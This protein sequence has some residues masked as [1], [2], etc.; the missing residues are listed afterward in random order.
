VLNDPAIDVI[1]E[2]I[3]GY[4]PARKFVLA[5]I[6]AGKDVVTANKALLAVYGEEIVA[7]AEARGVRLGFEASV[8]GGIPILRTLKEGLAGDRTS[9]VYGI[10]NGTCN[11]ILTTMSREGRGFDDVLAEAQRLGLAEANPATDVDGI[12]SAHKLA[13]LATLAFGVRPR[14]ADIPTEGIRRV[15]AIDIAFA[16]ELGYTIKLL[17]I[18]KDGRDA[19]EARVHPTMIPNGHLLADVSGAFNAIF[20]RGAA[21]G[22]TMYYGQGAGSLPTATA[23]IADLVAATRDRAVGADVRVPPWGVPQRALRALPVAPL[24]ALESEYYLRFMA[25]DR[26]GVLARIAGVLGR[27]DISIASVIQRDRRA[28]T[29]VPVVI[30]THRARERDL[31]KALAAIDALATVRG[32]PVAIRIEE[33]LG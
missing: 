30:R 31:A 29:A 10:V 11:H 28:G 4:E 13:L 25:T 2:L 20:V 12:D 33:Q 26:P 18:A 5:A 17:A 3:G 7:A 14:F 6:A 22:P 19:F 1:I 24:A 9:A 27:F 21:L 8:G 23:V 15:D 32:K 16:R